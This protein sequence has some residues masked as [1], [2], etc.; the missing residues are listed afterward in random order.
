M[1]RST[2]RILTTHVGSLIRPAPLLPFIRAKQSGEPYDERA[3]AE[4]LAGSVA[5][6]VRQQAAAGVDIPS[7]GE[8]GKAIS[9]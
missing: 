6:V 1:R 3:Y 4:C 7:D 5:D 2:E 8:F 9:W